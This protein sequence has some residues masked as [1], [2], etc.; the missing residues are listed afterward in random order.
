[1]ILSFLDIDE[2]NYVQI[3]EKYYLVL[4][5][6]FLNFWRVKNKFKCG[7]FY[8]QI[9][10]VL[11]KPVCSDSRINFSLE[12]DLFYQNIKTPSILNLTNE[13]VFSADKFTLQ[14]FTG[15]PYKLVSAYC[16]VPEGKLTSFIPDDDD[17]NNETIQDI[18]LDYKTQNNYKIRG[19]RVINCFI[20]GVYTKNNNEKIQIW[21]INKGKFKYEK[22]DNILEFETDCTKNNYT[23]GKF[24]FL[25][26]GQQLLNSLWPNYGTWLNYVDDSSIVN[27]T[28]IKKGTKIEVY[29]Y[30]YSCS[31]KL[32]N[33]AIKIK[34]KAVFKA[35]SLN[36]DINIFADCYY[37]ANEEVPLIFENHFNC[38]V[39]KDQ[40]I[41]SRYLI[42]KQMMDCSGKTTYIVPTLEN[43]KENEGML[44]LCNTKS[45]SN[46]FKHKYEK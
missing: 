34:T 33:K 45:S 35:G 8:F 3:A 37:N 19:S 20:V 25:I 42:L 36:N 6:S 22:K 4:K 38:F 44:N 40:K 28:M 39:K 24:E 41:Y 7:N 11:P 18:I 29:M 12:A 5:S 17:N 46:L 9:N 43:K 27:K 32:F 10:K 26:G 21:G 1:M 15:D 14:L 30:C 23:T 31:E 16:E 13:T 2:I